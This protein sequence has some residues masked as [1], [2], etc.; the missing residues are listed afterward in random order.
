MQTREIRRGARVVHRLYG[1]G[2]V[3]L[4]DPT[5]DEPQAFVRFDD[6]PCRR[7]VLQKH[8]VLEPPAMPPIGRPSLEVVS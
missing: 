2:L 8:L 7:R 6:D 3:Q 5:T 4:L 1:R